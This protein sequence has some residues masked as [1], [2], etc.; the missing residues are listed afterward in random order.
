MGTAAQPFLNP[1]AAEAE[2]A[3]S[4]H[5]AEA[6]ARRAQQ[7]RQIQGLIGVCYV[8]DA[9][10]L[11]LYAYAGTIKL[12]I[13]PAYGVCGLLLVAVTILLSE[14][15]FN[16]RFKDHYLVAPCAAANM[17]V[18]LT[19]TWIAPEVGVMFLCCL[20]TLFSF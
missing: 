4:R 15:G 19:F 17:V 9:G 7:R 3:G 5:S 13:G 6:L 10:I 20:F 1:I 14:I 12:W 2:V 16:E 11:L 8:I 18:V